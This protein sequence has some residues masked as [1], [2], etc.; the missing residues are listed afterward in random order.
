MRPCLHGILR[1]MVNGHA[2]MPLAPLPV[3]IMGWGVRRRLARRSR[4]K[5]HRVSARFGQGTMEVGLKKRWK[6]LMK[7]VLE[8]EGSP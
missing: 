6:Q 7:S 1:A 2:V 4:A 8:R 3:A 5:A